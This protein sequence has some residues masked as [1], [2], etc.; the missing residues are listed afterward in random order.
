MMPRNGQFRDLVLSSEALG[1]SSPSV[2]L[3][4]L[5]ALIEMPP[6]EAVGPALAFALKKLEGSRDHW[7]PSAFSLA[8]IHN[9]ASFLDALVASLP[10]AEQGKVGEPGAKKMTVNLI[11][12]ASFE[13]VAG[14]NPKGWHT[15][16]WSGEPKLALETGLAAS[17]KHCIRVSADK[18]TE[19]GYFV[20]VDVKPHMIYRLRR[21]EE[22]TSELQ[23][24]A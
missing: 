7:I 5:L 21:S 12:N 24:Q 8:A 19:A 3:A 9:A 22:H 10:P 18:I 2:Q 11:P 14:K 1:D 13:E 20:E 4:A 23:S 6:T 15:R 17:G 16:T